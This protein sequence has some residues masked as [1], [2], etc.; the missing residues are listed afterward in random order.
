[1]AWPL[2]ADCDV[3]PSNVTGN[4]SAAATAQVAK[5]ISWVTFSVGLPVIGLALYTLKNLSKGLLSV[6]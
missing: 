5:V 2:M 6:Q 3:V 4:T 1:M